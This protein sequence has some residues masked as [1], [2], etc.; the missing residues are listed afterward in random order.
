MVQ[1][2]KLQSRCHSILR[3]FVGTC[4]HA[5]ST[6]YAD[7][8]CT[9]REHAL[10]FRPGVKYRRI[11]DYRSYDHGVVPAFRIKR[12]KTSDPNAVAS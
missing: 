8:K 6:S 7:P 5:S 10:F 3:Y 9:T 4:A 2:Y 11:Y 1:S 12:P